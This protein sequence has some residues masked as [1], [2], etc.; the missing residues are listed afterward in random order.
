MHPTLAELTAAL[1]HVQAAPKDGAALSMLCFRPAYNE[2]RFVD[3][4]T[5]TRERGIPDERW[6]RAPW[7]RTDDGAAHPGIQVSILQRRVLDLV[8]RDRDG[9]VHPGDTAIADM[10][11]SEANL[12]TGQLLRA[13]TAILRVSEVFNDA[14]VKWKVRYGNDA[15]D[16]V[17]AHPQLRLR[18]ILC[19]IEQDG[20]MRAGDLLTKI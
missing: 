8:W 18:G 9:T 17:R 2:R 10:D 14:C 12:P 5:L 20:E 15:L 4:L 7:L 13:G 16:W 19:A 6:E 11:M 1:P 3:S